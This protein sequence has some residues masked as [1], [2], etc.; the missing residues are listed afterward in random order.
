MKKPFRTYFKIISKK[1]KIN[2]KSNPKASQE[3]TQV[4]S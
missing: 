4:I 1:S 3:S 2:K